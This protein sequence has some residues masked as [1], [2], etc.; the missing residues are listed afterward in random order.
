MQELVHHWQWAVGMVHSGGSQDDNFSE[1]SQLK[2]PP[3]K[4]QAMSDWWDKRDWCEFQSRV[5]EEVAPCAPGPKNTETAVGG[6]FSSPNR[7]LMADLRC[8][9]SEKSRPGDHI[10]RV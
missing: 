1:S 2:D 4:L 7:E 5:V 8:F 9:Q 3:E 6:T 10:E